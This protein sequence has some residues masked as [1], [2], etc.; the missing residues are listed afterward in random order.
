MSSASQQPEKSGS[1]SQENVPQ[2]VVRAGKTFLCSSCGTLVEVP[3]DVVGQLVVAVGHSPQ[4]SSEGAPVV[5]QERAVDDTPER[6]TGQKSRPARPARPKQPTRDSFTGQTID[7]L[8]VPSSQELDRA[9]AWVSFHLK[10]LDRQGSE[11]KRLKKLLKQQ[12]T[13]QV[14]C[15][16]SAGH[17]KKVTLQETH[18]F[19]GQRLQEHAQ[20]D[21]GM[22]ANRDNQHKRGP[23]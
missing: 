12:P 15:P 20:A 9:L 2:V 16:R 1:R 10:V 17:A 3:A 8:R 21:Q 11:I 14:P 23:P 5:Q 4:D 22:A 19:P 13:A 7:G 18:E 6:S